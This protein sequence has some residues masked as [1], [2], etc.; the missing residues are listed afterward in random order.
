MSLIISDVAPD[1]ATYRPNEPA[2]VDV[3]L[4]NQS[5]ELVTGRVV[6]AL[7][8]LDT[9]IERQ[10]QE[11]ALAPGAWAR[12]SFRLTPPPTPPHPPSTRTPPPAAY[13]SAVVPL[14]RGSG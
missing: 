9:E 8:H 11:L 4:A 1:R 10:A 2:R 3:T 14:R 7:V 13:R 12:I 5:A 6:L